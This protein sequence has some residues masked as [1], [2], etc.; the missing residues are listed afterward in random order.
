MQKM[1]HGLVKQLLME[2]ML[3]SHVVL[4]QHLVLRCKLLFKKKCTQLTVFLLIIR[5]FLLYLLEHSTNPN[6]MYRSFIK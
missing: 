1:V 3:R 6:W 2:N 4:L 5:Y